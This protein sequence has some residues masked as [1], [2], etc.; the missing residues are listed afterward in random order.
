MEKRNIVGSNI[1]RFRLDAG[2]TQEE[3]A[4]ISGLS[5]GYINQLENGRR[6]YTQKSLE[7]IAHAMSIPLIEFFKE[8]ESKQVSFVA[9]KGDNYQKKSPNKREFFQL[10]SDLPEHIIDHYLTLLKL[11]RELVS[12]NKKNAL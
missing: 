4:L 2:I 12:K 5:Q 1:R 7:L 11:E 10:L 6:N 8:E 3:L 9:E